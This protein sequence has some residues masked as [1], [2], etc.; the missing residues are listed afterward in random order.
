MA[1]PEVVAVFGAVAPPR[2]RHQTSTT[3]NTRSVRG[4]KHPEVS[5]YVAEPAGLRCEV[6]TRGHEPDKLEEN[7][8]VAVR[9]VQEALTNT[10]RHAQATQVRVRLRFMAGGRIGVLVELK[11]GDVELARG[12][13]MHVAAMNPP[14]NKAADVPA[15]FLAKE[16]EIELAKMSEKD[17]AK[18]AEILEKIISGKIAKIVNDKAYLKSTTLLDG[19]VGQTIVRGSKAYLSSQEYFDPQNGQPGKSTVKLNEVD[20]T[21]PKKPI[22]KSSAPKDGW[23][24]LVDVE[25]D[26]VRSVTVHHLRDHADVCKEVERQVMEKYGIGAKPTAVAAAPG[27]SMRTSISSWTLSIRFC[28]EVWSVSPNFNLP[29]SVMA[30]RSGARQSGSRRSRLTS[31]SRP[32]APTTERCWP[33]SARARHPLDCA[34]A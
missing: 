7:A 3:R 9:L 15:E 10:V 24:W 28:S 12:I 16:K 11:G 26:R 29:M 14:Y 13:A 5:A 20:L 21:D 2:R 8:A 30:L 18:P 4:C 32:S 6:T 19:W 31:G 34:S 1:L 27:T 17:K 25:G 23:G 22:V 33:G